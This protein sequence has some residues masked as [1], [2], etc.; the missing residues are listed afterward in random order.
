MVDPEGIFRRKKIWRPGQV[1][2]PPKIT[3]GEHVGVPSPR[4]GAYLKKGAG[5]GARGGS[6]GEEKARGGRPTAGT[7][8]SALGPP[9]SELPP[10]PPY[11]YPP[12]HHNNSD[13]RIDEVRK[14]R[15]ARALHP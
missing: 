12:L 7:Y 10:P 15:L 11:C 3:R 4:Q 8:G 2:S 14:P 6:A 13:P 9:T 1:E 5:G